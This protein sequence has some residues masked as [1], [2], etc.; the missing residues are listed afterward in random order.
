MPPTSSVPP[1]APGHQT[2]S[3]PR[4]TA[5]AIPL[6][7]AG[8]GIGYSTL[9][10]LTVTM[11]FGLRFRALVS[12]PYRTMILDLGPLSLLQ[13]AFCAAC[14]PPSGTWPNVT[15][16]GDS[17]PPGSGLGK[18]TRRNESGG[19]RKRP[20]TLGKNAPSGFRTWKQ[21]AMVIYFVLHT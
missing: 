4:P 11:L 21:K 6:R 18:T 14:L 10:T 12:D 19:L 1:P 7:S 2:D 15:D 16:D 9:H 3:R 13:C 17:E 8:Y 5:N 20:A